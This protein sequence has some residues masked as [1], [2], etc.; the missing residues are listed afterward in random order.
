VI[1]PICT[2][3]VSMVSLFEGEGLIDEFKS[4]C[5]CIS[6]FY[7]RVRACSRDGGCPELVHFQHPDQH[8]LWGEMPLSHC[9]DCYQ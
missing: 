7:C 6:H 3:L 8:D 4:H 5:T 9:A 1:C 2:V